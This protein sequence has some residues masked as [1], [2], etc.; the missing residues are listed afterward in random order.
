MPALRLFVAVEPP[1]AVRRRLAALQAE[2]RRAAGRAADDVRWVA[3]EQ[4]HLTLAFLGNAPEERID[5]VRGAVADAAAA[6]APLHLEVRGA[7]GFPSARR[8]RV[9]WAGLAGDLEPLGALAAD[10]RRRL[11]PLGFPL[12]E[13]DFRAHLTLGR[14]RDRGGARG[15]AGA[16][17]AANEA[18][19]CAWRAD[20]VVLFRSHLGPGG[21]RHE[22]LQRAE[23]GAG[24]R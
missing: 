22:A 15:M 20:E 7:G 5:A 4:I 3:P 13:R 24:A 18:D 6:C 11:A 17:A 10:L 16:L 19:P 21:A 1:P 9:V 14:S 2:V 8:P 12:E 23:M